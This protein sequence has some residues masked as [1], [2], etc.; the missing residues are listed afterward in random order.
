MT[1]SITIIRTTEK[2]LTKKYRRDNIEDARS[3]IYI[4]IYKNIIDQVS[5]AYVIRVRKVVV[6]SN[7]SLIKKNL[8]G[9][10]S[11]PACI[12]IRLL[13]IYARTRVSNTRLS[14]FKSRFSPPQIAYSYSVGDFSHRLY[15]TVRRQ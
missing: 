1:I 4:Y 3:V 7:R 13:N 10:R 5:S 6:A 12:F 14:T 9:P 11:C 15:Y 8:R 2:R